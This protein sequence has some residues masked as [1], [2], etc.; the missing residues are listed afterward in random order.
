MK[1]KRII[2]L[3]LTVA[4]MLSMCITG[5]AVDTGETARGNES[6]TPEYTNYKD[7]GLMLNDMNPDVIKKLDHTGWTVLTD[8]NAQTELA[9][10]YGSYYLTG[11][12]TENLTIPKPRVL[13]SVTICLEGKNI[14]GT[15][16]VN[17]G[18]VLNIYDCQQA[19][20]INLGKIVNKGGTINL[21]R[22]NSVVDS[23]ENSANGQDVFSTTNIVAGS[24]TSEGN[25]SNT[26]SDGGVSTL[27]ITGIVA[28]SINGN[29][30]NKGNVTN[31]DT[32]GVAVINFNNI[33]ITG[34]VENRGSIST[35]LNLTGSTVN[36]S[37]QNTATANLY[38][39][40][41]DG[42]IVNTEKAAVLNVYDSSVPHYDSRVPYIQST[43][44]TLNVYDSQITNTNG[45]AIEISNGTLNLSGTTVDGINGVEA[46]NSATLNIKNST[47]TGTHKCGIDM[48]WDTN[49]P[50][51]INLE[52][53]TISGQ[54][55][56]INSFGDGSIGDGSIGD[57]S[58]GDGV[59]AINVV[60]ST[61][62]GSGEYGIYNIGKGA[63]N[64]GSGVAIKGG[65]T[66]DVYTDT[67]IAA[68]AYGTQYS[69]NGITI[70][71]GAHLDP[72][73]TIF[74]TNATEESVFTVK[75][76]S[77]AEISCQRFGTNLATSCADHAAP[78]KN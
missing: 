74:V 65:S 10:G 40:V 57:G 78:W 63:I 64:L 30:T 62:T 12:L 32:N 14:L 43:D 72:V 6:S 34:D 68:C 17:E 35:T 61:I 66:A 60:D 22:V 28:P 19:T 15:I 52:K 50:G 54:T 2:S 47:V 76:S 45:A 20:S 26:A 75:D 49:T 42:G 59:H 27:N 48:A 73:Q 29:V 11:D 13:N 4:M 38:E 44:G 39:S 41:V 56:G 23:I 1:H 51:A 36:G 7:R 53:S 24:F 70:Q 71:Y 9:K 18:A 25:V 33:T 55:Y 67:S 37:I 21:T 69:G 77:G 31:S 16:T 46:T 58:I 3:V 8:D 5:F